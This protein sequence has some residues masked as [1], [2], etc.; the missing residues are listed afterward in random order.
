MTQAAFCLLIG[1]LAMMLGILSSTPW[2]FV[3]YGC[4]LF[5]M[6][7]FIVVTNRWENSIKSSLRPRR[8]TP[9]T[10]GCDCNKP[11]RPTWLWK[12]P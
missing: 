3:F 11:V 4:A 9:Q 7:M 8:S 10:R 2:C 5:W 1:T 12:N 6:I